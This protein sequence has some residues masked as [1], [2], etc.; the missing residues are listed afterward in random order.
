MAATRKLFV[1]KNPSIGHPHPRPA[2]ASGLSLAKLGSTLVT[3]DEPFALADLPGRQRISLACKGIFL[4][5]ENDADRRAHQVE[6]FAV[7]VDQ[8]APVRIGDVIRLIAVDDD[9]GRI[10]STLMRIAKLD[11]AA[12]HQRRLMA[13]DGRF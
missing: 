4:T 5:L 3:L 10:L 7:H 1:F 13:F 11:A 2:A 8:V 6:G 12:A 9:D